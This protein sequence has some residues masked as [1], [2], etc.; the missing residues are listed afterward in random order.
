MNK[1]IINVRS[2]QENSLKPWKEKKCEVHN[3]KPA[4]LLNIYYFTIIFLG[5]LQGL[6]RS[7]RSHMFFKIGVL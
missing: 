6:K 3:K 2:L 7:S 4:T 1:I 5:I